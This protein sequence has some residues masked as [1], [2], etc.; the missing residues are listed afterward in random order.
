[1]TYTGAKDRQILPR[2]QT[3]LNPVAYDALESIYDDHIAEITAAYGEDAAFR[4][5]NLKFNTTNKVSSVIGR[6]RKFFFCVFESDILFLAYM[7]ETTADMHNNSIH[8]EMLRRADPALLDT[9]PFEPGKSFAGTGRTSEVTEFKGIKRIGEHRKFIARNFESII[10]HIHTHGYHL[11]FYRPDYL[12]SIIGMNP[13]A[14][15]EPIVNKLYAILGTLE[16]SGY[17][18]TDHA[19]IAGQNNTA[20]DLY[21]T[22][23]FQQMY[24]DGA[25]HASGLSG[26][27]YS[28]SG[29]YRSFVKIPEGMQLRSSIAS[30]ETGQK[31]KT[32]VTRQED[33][34]TIHFELEAD[35]RYRVSHI[36]YNPKTKERTKLFHFNFVAQ[37][38]S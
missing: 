8:Y 3:A 6:M 7:Q 21:T 17:P 37:D 26:M 9:I 36:A 19:Q 1:M 5:F 23:L 11:K 24:F 33:G 14:L 15:P 34:H 25:L 18:L 35:G 2:E 30:I 28:H 13:T 29:V 22:D 12:D 20:A 10:S 31:Q 32:K 27:V 38:V 4:M 16:M